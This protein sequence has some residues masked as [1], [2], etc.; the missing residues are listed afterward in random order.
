MLRTILE[1]PVQ[2]IFGNKQTQKQHGKGELF[3]L[4][5]ALML[6]SGILIFFGGATISAVIFAFGYYCFKLM[7]ELSNFKTDTDL[8]PSSTSTPSTTPTPKT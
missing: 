3:F 4:V 2:L 5:L 8:S 6:V 1:T 7:G